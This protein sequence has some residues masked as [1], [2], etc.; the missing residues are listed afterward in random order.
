MSGRVKI[1]DEVLYIFVSFVIYGFIYVGSMEIFFN[2]PNEYGYNFTAFFK[3][4]MPQYVLFSIITG[5]GGFHF[6]R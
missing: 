3:N 5:G 1:K 4:I 2:N 6:Y